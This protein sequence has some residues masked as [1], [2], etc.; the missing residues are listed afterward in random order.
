M[1]KFMHSDAARANP[2]YYAELRREQRR[3]YYAQTSYAYPPKRWEAWEDELVM[4]DGYTTRE[5]SETLGR[6]MKS[7]SNRRWRL[8][9]QAAQQQAKG[10]PGGT[11]ADAS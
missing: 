7:V 5:L 8:R 3:R 9:K 6:S 4:S 1:P 11:G 10:A 2:G